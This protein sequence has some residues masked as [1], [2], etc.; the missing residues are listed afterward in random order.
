[1]V[2]YLNSGKFSQYGEQG[3]IDEIIKRI[4]LPVGNAVEFGAPTKQYCSNIYHLKDNGWKLFYYDSNPQ[5]DGIMRMFV[6]P[7][8][9]NDMQECSI[10]SCDTDGACAGLWAAYKGEPDIV[11][12]EINSSLSPD[13]DYFTIE[14]GANY[15]YMKKLGEVKGYKLLIHT[16]NMIF[17]LNKYAALF[18]DADETFKTDWLC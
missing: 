9:V 5:E 3:V 13:V 14:N 12:I 10:W 18:P 11:I 17:V 8:N 2:K 6:T 4:K 16:G 7:E 1:M 15:S